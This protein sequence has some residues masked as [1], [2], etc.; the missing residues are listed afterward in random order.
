[1]LKVG[2]T[3]NIACGKSFI[4]KLFSLYGI[5]IIDSD[6][7]AREVVE[8]NSPTLNKIVAHFGQ[9]ILQ[10]D[11]SLDRTK[12]RGLVFADKA[13]LAALNAITH[14]AIHDRTI[15]LCNTCAQGL[16]LDEN[17]LNF[18]QKQES[19]KK[20]AQA[21]LAMSNDT[22]HNNA[23]STNDNDAMSELGKI[24]LSEPLDPQ[25]VIGPEQ[26]PPYIILDIPLLFE[27][28]LEHMVDTI[29]VVDATVQTQLSRII[30]RDHCSLE[31][32]QNIIDK[33]LSRDY[34]RQ[35]A[36]D[37]IQT[38]ILNIAEKRQHVLNLHIKYLASSQDLK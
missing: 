9:D 29:L 22:K 12:L 26:K 6:M 10:S 19:L 24:A 32:A 38:D 4:A 3:G 20:E 11:G 14:P 13:K 7:I 2:L 33:Q 16:P 8:P 15:E 25:Y 28:H 23:T 18:C 1:M 34:K 31:V 5:R 17:Y 35:H 36:D 37:I 21:K 27:N 30:N